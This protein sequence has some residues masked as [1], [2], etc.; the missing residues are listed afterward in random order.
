MSNAEA[1]QFERHGIITCKHHMVLSIV[2]CRDRDA[3]GGTSGGNHDK[4]NN[5]I[6]LVAFDCRSQHCIGRHKHRAAGRNVCVQS[7]TTKRS[8]R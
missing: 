2:V 8:K 1:V 4:E 6:S 7:S 3:R 5:E